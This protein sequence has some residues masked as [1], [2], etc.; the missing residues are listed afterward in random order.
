MRE[1]LK[2]CGTAVFVALVA[3]AIWPEHKDGVHY[4]KIDAHGRILIEGAVI[5]YEEPMM[6]IECAWPTKSATEK[7]N[8]VWRQRTRRD[9]LLIEIDDEACVAALCRAM[10]LFS[11]VGAFECRLVCSGIEGVSLLHGTWGHEARFVYEEGGKITNVVL[12]R[13]RVYFPGESEFGRCRSLSRSRSLHMPEECGAR[14]FD[15]HAV[16]SS[17][18]ETKGGGNSIQVYCDW[19]MPVRR[20]KDF[21]RFL[22]K[23]GYVKFCI[24]FFAPPQGKVLEDSM[25][26]SEDRA[27]EIKEGARKWWED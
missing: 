25:V 3:Y 6:S 1:C 20:L 4:A 2:W 15:D 18:E 22:G 23:R 26:G 19:D 10:G 16:L 17:I 5:S 8:A 7:L 12:T 11:C 27:G 21:I 14:A 13:D 24:V 9:S